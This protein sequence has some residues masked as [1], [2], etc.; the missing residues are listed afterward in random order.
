[1]FKNFTKKLSS[2]FIS[3]KIDATTL[4][5]LEELLLISDVGIETVDKILD[6]LKI[7]KFSDSL[8]IIEIKTKLGKIILD[9]IE[10]F[11]VKLP[12][13]DKEL[14]LIIFCIGVN[15]SGKTTTIAKLANHYK[16]QGYKVILGAADTFRAAATQQ[17][18]EWANQ[19]NLE[20]ITGADNSDPASVVYQ[21]VE[22]TI[23]NNFNIGIIDTAGRLQNRSDLMEQLKKMNK[24]IQNNNLAVIQKTIMVVDSTTGQSTIKQVQEFAKYVSID[25]LILSKFDGSA[26]GGTIV[27]IINQLKIPIIG[28]GTGEKKEDLEEFDSNKFIKRMLES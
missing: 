16:A 27:S 13:I 6:K 24:V 1:L 4:L 11:E 26:I 22:N 8:D 5:E 7:E 14:P 2:I 20:I 17:L 10:P 21:C 9:I 18:S 23:N 19:M 12:K 15:G 28:I 25:G 3:K